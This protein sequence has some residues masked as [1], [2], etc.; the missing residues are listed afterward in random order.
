M[1]SLFPVHSSAALVSGYCIVN[2]HQSPESS[3][4]GNSW[5]SCLGNSQRTLLTMIAYD[6]I[7]NKFLLRLHES[8]TI[9][10]IWKIN[11]TIECFLRRYS[12]LGVDWNNINTSTCDFAHRRAAS[13]W[14]RPDSWLDHCVTTT[15]IWS[16]NFCESRMVSVVDWIRGS[17]IAIS[18]GCWRR[19][20]L[21]C[22]WYLSSRGQIRAGCDGEFDPILV[23]QDSAQK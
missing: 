8:V 1:K 2:K 10:C 4:L 21:D 11:H 9:L 22:V 15:I 7:K 5:R 14:I 12:R 16:L 13:E 23:N 19:D 3:C 17:Y 6:F 18:F 20:L